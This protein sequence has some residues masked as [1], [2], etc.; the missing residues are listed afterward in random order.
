M[1]E[2]KQ[3]QQSS[4]FQ[5]VLEL[6]LSLFSQWHM[7]GARVSRV[8]RFSQ[9][10]QYSSVLIRKLYLLDLNTSLCNC[11]LDFLSESVNVN[12]DGIQ[13]FGLSPLL[14]TLVTHCTTM[15]SSNHTKFASDTMSNRHT[16]I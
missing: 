11:I 12:V 15:Y 7:G 16:L 5:H 1:P 13:C 9:H 4:P 10:L 6:E 14:F 2:E 3:Q 8:K